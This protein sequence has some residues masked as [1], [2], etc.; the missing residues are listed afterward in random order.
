LPPED[1]KLGRDAK[2]CNCDSPTKRREWR[3]GNEPPLKVTRIVEELKLITVKAVPVSQE[4]MHPQDERSEGAQKRC[5]G[6]Q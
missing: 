6:A 1:E 4:K 5:V 2:E 3:I